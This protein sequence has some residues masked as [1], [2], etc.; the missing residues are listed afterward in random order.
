[1]GYLRLHD[2]KHS[3]ASAMISAHVHLYT[4]SAVLGHK[5]AARTQRYSHLATAAMKSA[6]GEI[7]KKSHTQKK[8]RVA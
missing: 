5:S 1:M 6:L 2:L 4:V 7:G 8:A 3:A